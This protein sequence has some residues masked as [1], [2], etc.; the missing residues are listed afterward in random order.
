MKGWIALLRSHGESLFNT[1]PGRECPGLKGRKNCRRKSDRF[2]QPPNL[3]EAQRVTK[4][5][6]D[7]LYGTES[8]W[9]ARGERGAG[10]AGRVPRPRSLPHLRSGGHRKPPRAGPFPVAHPL[11]SPFPGLCA[12]SHQWLMLVTF[13][14]LLKAST[15]LWIATAWHLIL[16][17]WPVSA[18]QADTSHL[19]FDNLLNLTLKSR[20]PKIVGT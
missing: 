10:P 3:K 8:P 18:S 4:I 6:T 11:S 17:P 1:L 7:G 14:L 20:L 19:T 12:C 16:A 15:R 9:Y 13:P 2:S 5:N